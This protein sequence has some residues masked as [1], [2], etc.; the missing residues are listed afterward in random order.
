MGIQERKER[1]KEHR[2]EEILNAAQK[3]FFTKGLQAATMDE[4]AEVAELS[5]GTLYLYYKS[6]E[7]LYLAVMM[8]GMGILYTMF[9]PIALSQEPTVV[10]LMKMTEAY[11]EFFQKHR[12]YFR[13][14]YFLQYPHFHKQVSDEMLQSCTGENQRVWNLALRVIQQGVEDGDLRSDISPMEMGVIIWSSANAIMMRMDTQR[15]YFQ[16]TMQV[17]LED[18]LR[19]SNTLLLESFMTENAKRK[20]ASLFRLTEKHE[21][22]V[23]H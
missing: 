18:V 15:D 12:N 17:N 6:K 21:R 11:Y 1:E 22:A 16:D 10:K 19:L 3:V 4:V 8:R 7:D 5:K 2:R 9:E 23:P 13:M 14:F 20:Y